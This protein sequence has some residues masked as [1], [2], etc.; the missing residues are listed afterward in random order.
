M[1][2]RYFEGFG[3]EAR[4]QTLYHRWQSAPAPVRHRLSL[5]RRVLDLAA[6]T[7]TPK[8][9]LPPLNWL[10]TFYKDLHQSDTTDNALHCTDSRSP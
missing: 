10:D 3:Q 4:S 5:F 9:R 2:Y 8:S 1:K 6:L 7:P